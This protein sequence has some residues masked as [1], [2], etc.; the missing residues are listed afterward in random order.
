MPQ[1]SIPAGSTFSIDV[2]VSVAQVG[3]ILQWDFM[4]EDKD[5]GFELSYRPPRPLCEEAVAGGTAAEQVP[6]GIV[7]LMPNERLDC[8]I[9]PES[10]IHVRIRC[11]HGCVGNGRTRV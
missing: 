1:T 10:G 5:C 9:V 3:S 7:T 4:S 2:E 11:M 6:N 8:N